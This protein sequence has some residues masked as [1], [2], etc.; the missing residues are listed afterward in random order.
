MP[1][2]IGA[3]IAP[4]SAMT[5]S[6]ASAAT[7]IP[8]RKIIRLV[9]EEVLPDSVCQISGRKRT[10]R[11]YSM[12]MTI[13]GASDAEALGK[14]TQL[15][16]M[17]LVG[18]FAKDNWQLLLDDPKQADSLNFA[19]G[20]IVVALG[21]Y[22]R[23]AMAGLNRLMDA[24]RRVVEDP[25]IRGGIPTIRGTRV[26]VY[27]IA[28]LRLNEEIDT[29]LEH[30]PRLRRKDVEAA[31]LYAKAYPIRRSKPITEA[32]RAKAYPGSRLVSETIMNLRRPA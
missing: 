11:A 24:H 15:A 16:I 4:N 29:I 13:F 18:K 7:G 17:R 5:I 9:D 31:S 30:Y 8:G 28:G 22:V 3:E 6:E 19:T 27:E 25:D 12:P 14:E 1:K 20:C 10:L 32:Q 23:E 21:N 26:G 2:F